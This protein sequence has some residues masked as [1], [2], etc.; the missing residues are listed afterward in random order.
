[1]KQKVLLAVDAGGT[2][3]EYCVKNIENGEMRRYTYGGLNYKSIGLDRTRSNLI[4][5]FIAICDAESFGPED[6]QGAVFG[7]SGCDT[8]QDMQHYR[9][10]IRLIGL[11][12][13][14][15]S[16]YNDCEL[17]FLATAG[18][19]GICVVAGT[20]SNCMAFKEGKPVM[21]AG[22]WGAFLSDGGSGYW[23]A[24]QALKDMLLYHDGSG[25]DK[26]VYARIAKH[27][28]IREQYEVTARFTSMDISE[29][30]SAARIILEC[31]AEGD[32]YSQ[33]ITSAAHAQLWDL[34]AALVQRIG[35]SSDE[36]LDVV[37]NGSLF[38][39]HWFLEYFWDGLA[40]RLPNPL[41]RYLATTNTSDNAMQVAHR[42][43]LP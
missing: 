22:G 4:T 10:M 32:P 42:L 37:L 3:T 2:K 16:L 33:Q 6:V 1:M 11:K 38:S 21:R 29:I 26:P 34:A 20:G 14:V 19:P 36:M 25:S 13:E 31:A 12:D 9:E 43:Y 18:S 28:G 30:A 23:I 41:V 5:G 40:K 15:T 35:F 7:I 39:N 17:V 24:Q 27:F 8:D